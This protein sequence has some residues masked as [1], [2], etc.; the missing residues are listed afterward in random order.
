MNATGTIDNETIDEEDTQEMQE[1]ETAATK[2]SYAVSGRTQRT[3]KQS[4][5]NP[6]KIEW[7]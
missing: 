4:T 6:M 5:N 2:Y 1:D 3:N 7:P